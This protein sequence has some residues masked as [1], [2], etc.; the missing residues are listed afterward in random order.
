MTTTNEERIAQIRERNA[1]LFTKISV[2]PSGRSTITS[3][4]M[5]ELAGLME[6]LETLLHL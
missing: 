6:E 1:E 3:D 2:F 5:E 4:E